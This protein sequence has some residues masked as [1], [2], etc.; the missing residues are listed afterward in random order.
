MPCSHTGAITHVAIDAC[1]GNIEHWSC[2]HDDTTPPPGNDG[3]T[4]RRAIFL[5]RPMVPV[6]GGTVGFGGGGKGV[7]ASPGP[8]RLQPM[9]GPTA[10]FSAPSEQ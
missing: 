3:E 9:P 5:G 8:N 6:L 2:C 1:T 10:S 7:I 4:R